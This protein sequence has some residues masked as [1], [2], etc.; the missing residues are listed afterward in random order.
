MRKLVL[1]LALASTAL[2]APS[3][4]NTPLDIAYP[5]T[6]AN[7][8]ASSAGATIEWMAANQAS[9]FDFAKFRRDDAMRNVLI[10][11]DQATFVP[12]AT[13]V[14]VMQYALLVRFSSVD[15]FGADLDPATRAKRI[16]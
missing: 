4:A 15:P 9:G 1:A 11:I 16:A 14:P 13:M 12:A 7:I 5:T 3:L 2:S 6:K 8:A 10:N